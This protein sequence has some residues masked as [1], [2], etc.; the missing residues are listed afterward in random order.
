MCLKIR[1]FRSLRSINMS[2]SLLRTTSCLLRRTI[3][4]ASVRYGHGPPAKPVDVHKGKVPSDDVK[5]PDSLGHSV[6]PERYELLAHESGEEDPFE[7][8][9]VKRAKGTFDEP[10]IVKSINNK[11][12]VGC[13]CEEDALTINW[14]Y[15][16]KGEPKRCECG[17]W[18]KLVDLPGGHH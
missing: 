4:V 9:V 15:V 18:F 17:Y 12:M 13:I 1:S 5:L 3:S 2:V 16:H 14:M 10:T 7:M 6:G 8:K 11:R